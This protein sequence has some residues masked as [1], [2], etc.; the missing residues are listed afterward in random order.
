[1]IYGRHALIYWLS[2]VM[3]FCFKAVIKTIGGE[4]LYK[5]LTCGGALTRL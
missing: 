3:C 2:L 1:M 5:T 4:M